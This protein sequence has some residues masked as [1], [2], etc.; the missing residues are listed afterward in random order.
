[1]GFTVQT[2]ALP[3]ASRRARFESSLALQ[4]LHLLHRLSPTRHVYPLKQ[5]RR[6]IR[7]LLGK[8]LHQ[9]SRQR[10]L[11]ATDI[12]RVHPFPEHLSQHFRA[13]L[14]KQRL[15]A[16]VT[17]QHGLSIWTYFLCVAMMSSAQTSLRWTRPRTWTPIPNFLPHTCRRQASDIH[18]L[19]RQLVLA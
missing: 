11:P 4:R 9:R 18:H 19:H 14:P 5:T 12:R 3:R 13:P 15:R 2:T 7:R 17:M 8:N 16:K 1:M 6:R 10:I